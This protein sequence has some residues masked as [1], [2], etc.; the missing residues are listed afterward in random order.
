MRPPLLLGVFLLTV[1]ALAQS[2]G[3]VLPAGPGQVPPRKMLYEHLRGEAQ[4][5]FDARRA[6]IA[7]LKTPADVQKR[8]AAAL[9]QPAARLELGCVLAAV[10]KYPDALAMLEGVEIGRES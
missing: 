7:A 8:Q 6:A 4:K 2:D 10:G 3:G 5:H 9:Q 1:P